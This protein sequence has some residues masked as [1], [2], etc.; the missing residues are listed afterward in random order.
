[1]RRGKYRK[2]YYVPGLTSLILVPLMLVYFGK[3]ELRNLDTRLIEVNAW[4]PD[5]EE[6]FPFPVRNYKE[7]I[8]TGNSGQ[9]VPAIKNTQAFI[10]QMYQETDTVNGIRFIFQDSASYGSFV[11]LLNFFKQDSIRYFAIYDNSI[12]VLKKPEPKEDTPYLF[13]CGTPDVYHSYDPYDYM[14]LSEK[15]EYHLSP[16][17]SGAAALWPALTILLLLVILSLW[18]ISSKKS[19]H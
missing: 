5:L 18:Q 2:L 6:H 19:I 7:I 4:H 11:S 1:M 10:R 17:R 8:L 15:I 3:D 13:V 9:D 14:T 12:W 16:Y